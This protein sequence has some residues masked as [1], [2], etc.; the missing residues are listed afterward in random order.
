MTANRLPLFLVIWVLTMFGALQIRAIPDEAFGSS[1][2][3][4]GPWGC[5]PP[6]KALVTMHAFWFAAL[7]P[8]VVFAALRWPVRVGRWL[9]AALIVAGMT[10]LLGVAAWEYAHWWRLVGE[11]QRQYAGQRYLFALATLVDAPIVPALLGGVTVMGIAVT[12]N[13]RDRGTADVGNR[14]NEPVKVAG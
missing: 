9:G 7:L 2:S 12:R 3:V 5:G 13:R 11:S 14:E 6:T 4:C 10:G 8:P 1:H